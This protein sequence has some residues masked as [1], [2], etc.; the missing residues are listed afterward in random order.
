MFERRRCSVGQSEAA[1]LDVLGRNNISSFQSLYVGL[2]IVLSALGY[3]GRFQPHHTK[4]EFLGAMV[5]VSSLAIPS[6]LALH[7]YAASLPVAAT[8]H[9][10]GSE[11]KASEEKPVT[12]TAAPNL[13]EETHKSPPTQP[14]E[15]PTS[16]ADN[17]LQTAPTSTDALPSR[18]N[19]LAP[20]N[21]RT[22]TPK[23]DPATHAH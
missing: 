4:K 1:T 15:K 8:E 6:V 13:G 21:E 17:T 3:H 14:A 7:S 18:Q 19:N 23:H 20:T 9:A 16:E 22:S 12:P 2:G 5:I 10:H 11:T